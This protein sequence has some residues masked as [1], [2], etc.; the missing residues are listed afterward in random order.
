MTR[1]VQTLDSKQ[2]HCDYPFILLF[3]SPGATASE[4]IRLLDLLEPFGN[5][6]VLERPPAV[7]KVTVPL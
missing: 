5:L 7:V 1:L 4:A 2:G 3:D 6:T